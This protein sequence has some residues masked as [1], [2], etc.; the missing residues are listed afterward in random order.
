MQSYSVRVILCKTALWNMLFIQF[1]VFILGPIFSIR[2]IILIS[3]RQFQSLKV[4]HLIRVYLTNSAY[5]QNRNTEG[6]TLIHQKMHFSNV[7]DNHAQKVIRFSEPIKYIASILSKLSPFSRIHKVLNFTLTEINFETFPPPHDYFVMIVNILLAK[8][9]CLVLEIS[10]M[11]HL[12]QFWQDISTLKTSYQQ[13]IQSRGMGRV[14]FILIYLVLAV[15]PT[16][17]W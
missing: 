5:K 3:N 10:L 16:K 9:V 6:S 15:D 7:H 17:H 14:V 1:V 13:F 8:L 11:F 12:N 4:S 2:I